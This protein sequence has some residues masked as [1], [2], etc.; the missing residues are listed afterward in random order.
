MENDV[1]LLAYPR[2]PVKWRII[3]YTESGKVY[4]DRHRSIYKLLFPNKFNDGKDDDDDDIEVT[5]SKKP[6]GDKGIY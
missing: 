5:V 3:E 4:Y 1:I 6:Y 2:G